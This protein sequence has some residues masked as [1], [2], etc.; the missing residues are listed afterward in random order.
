MAVTRVALQ[1][2]C[3]F[4]IF[5]LVEVRPASVLLLLLVKYVSHQTNNNLSF[6]A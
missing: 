6:L 2:A 1:A 5:N 3:F 4:S